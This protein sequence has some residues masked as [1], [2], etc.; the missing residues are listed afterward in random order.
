MNAMREELMRLRVMQRDGTIHAD[1]SMLPEDIQ[2]EILEKEVEI[3]KMEEEQGKM[4]KLVEELQLKM[5]VMDQAKQELTL[6]VS[7]QRRERFAAAFRNAFM[8]STGKKRIEQHEENLYRMRVESSAMKREIAALDA[9]VNLQT[10]LNNDLI[11]ENASLS[12]ALQHLRGELDHK[13]ASL[14]NQNHQ[15]GEMKLSLEARLEDAEASFKRVSSERDVK[16]M[17]VDSMKAD[18]EG[19]KHAA[20]RVIIEKNHIKASYEEAMLAH[21]AECDQLRRRKERYKQV[22]AQ[23]KQRSNALQDAPEH[24]EADK[25]SL[26]E[27]VKALQRLLDEKDFLVSEANRQHDEAR[28]ALEEM[29]KKMLECNETN[30][31]LQEVVQ[32]YHAASCQFMTDLSMRDKEVARLRTITETARHALERGPGVRIFERNPMKRNGNIV[33]A[34]AHRSPLRARSPAL[35]SRT[36]AFV[37]PEINF[38]SRRANSSPRR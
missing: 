34:A 28:G 11:A 31:I 17:Q 25:A 36:A 33:A 27:T 12:T 35:S 20:E 9:E 38:S 21:G 3:A 4:A 1:V 14:E 2:K 18:L 37:P 5:K 19:L 32:E 23:E 30:R 16:K 6:A 29:E 10:R 26:L 24:H 13:V 7:E 15:L 22:A 8:I